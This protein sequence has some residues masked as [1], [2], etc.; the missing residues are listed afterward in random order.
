MKFTT[1]L[2][3]VNVLKVSDVDDGAADLR[4]RPSTYL[5]VELAQGSHPTVVT[6]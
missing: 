4:E 3:L 5:E 2:T 1:E 6:F